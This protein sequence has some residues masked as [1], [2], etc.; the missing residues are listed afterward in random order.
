MNYWYAE[1]VPCRWQESFD[2]ED[3][4]I[5]AA[6]VH[7]RTEHMSLFSIS[8]D[9]R[10]R[11]MADERIGHVQLRDERA[12]AVPTASVVA[13][14][15]TT[16]PLRTLDDELALEEEQLHQQT[17]KVANLRQQ[18]DSAAKESS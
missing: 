1:C 16:V 8:S 13:A 12:I 14:P 9:A 10:S 17:M 6:E 18:R 4:A 2:E 15:S 11:K 5:I 3:S 7:T